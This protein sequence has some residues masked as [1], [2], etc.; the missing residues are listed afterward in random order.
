MYVYIYICI[1]FIRL[2]IC[3]Y[4]TIMQLGLQNHNRDALVGPNSIIV[5][6]MDPSGS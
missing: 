4:T 2:Y 1:Y 3:I 5:V 6:Y